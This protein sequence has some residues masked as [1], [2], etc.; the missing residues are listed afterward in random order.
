MVTIVFVMVSINQIHVRWLRCGL[1]KN[2]V[3]WFGFVRCLCVYCSLHGFGLRVPRVFGL[4]GNVLLMEFVGE[5]G[6]PAPR[7]K[8]VELSKK[9]YE[10]VY[11][12]LVRTL[13]E[14]YQRCRLVHGDL[15]E[16]N[17]L[18]HRKEVWMIDVSQSVEIDHPNALYFLRSDCKNVSDYFSK[19]VLA[20]R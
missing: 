20:V 4:S 17:L 13:R 7:L 1:I 15:S 2:V 11:L 16:Y 14:M 5:N 9:S 19:C 12:D 3:I 6:W 18:Y 8:D 10:R